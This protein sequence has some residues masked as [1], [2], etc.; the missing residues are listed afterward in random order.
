MQGRP[1]LVVRLVHSG[2]LLHQEAYYLQV[3]IDAGLGVETGR[4]LS[5]LCPA[6]QGPVRRRRPRLGETPLPLHG[7]E[8]QGFS[9][10]MG[11]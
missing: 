7:R 4:E 10:G 2:A 6:P 11:A 5:G 9:S 8:E 1:A 3:L